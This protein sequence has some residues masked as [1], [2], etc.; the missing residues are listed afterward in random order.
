MGSYR[1]PGVYI[2]E[3]PMRDPVQVAISPAVTGFIGIAPRGKVGEAVLVTSWTDYVNKFALGTE[4]PFLREANLSYAVLGFFLNGG[5]MAYIVRATDGTEAEAS[6]TYNDGVTEGGATDIVKF[7]A[8][9]PGAWGNNLGV[10]LTANGD[11]FDIEIILGYEEGTSDGE[12]VYSRKNVALEDF[13]IINNNPYVKAEFLEY[14]V[15]DVETLGK[16]QVLTGGDDGIEDIDDGDYTGALEAFN[17]IDSLAL[18]TCVESQSETVISAGI[19]YCELRKDCIYV[20]DAEEE[21][22]SEDA[23]DLVSNFDSSYA[24]CIYPWIRVSDPIATGADK[25]RYIPAAGHYCGV[26]A[27]IANNRSIYKAPAGTEATVKGAMGVKWDITE[28]EH[29]DLNSNGINAIR[30]F[31]NLG[32]VVWG[33]KTIAKNPDD[34]TYINLRLGLNYIKN[35]LKIN[36]RWAV[37][38]PNNVILWRKMTVFLKGF[39]LGEYALGGFKGATPAEAFFVKC[40][41]ELNDINSIR[42]GKVKAQIGV[43]IAEPGEFVIIE[44]GQ[45][46]SG[47]SAEEI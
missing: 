47:S 16:V 22:V 35:F 42:Q 19:T 7:T 10:K 17:K 6:F 24:A 29:G 41:G 23:I 21:N 31:R 33:A 36:T 4:S 30:A 2:S 27:R 28:S 1:T 45:W 14:G 44:V 25:T 32:I 46:D 5:S 12:I 11:N 9:D 20:F 37:F 38:E 40:D 26:I 39:L 43:S 18:I 3:V 13:E 15:I 34:I 8:L